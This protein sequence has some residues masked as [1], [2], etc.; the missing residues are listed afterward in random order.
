M[1]ALLET[2]EVR[3]RV[4][5]L[6]PRYDGDPAGPA[7]G[8][9][10]RM[11]AGRPTA[12]QRPVTGTSTVDLLDPGRYVGVAHLVLTGLAWRRGG[13]DSE[14]FVAAVAEAGASALGVGEGL[15]GE[16]PADVVRA[17]RRHE[18]PLFAVPA[19]L[20][21]HEISARVA[22]AVAPG[23]GPGSGAGSAGDGAVLRVLRGL[24][25]GRP[26]SEQV[27]DVAAHLGRP[28]R[29][30]S[31]TGRLVAGPA[32][33]SEDEADD[34]VRSGARATARGAAGPG[35]VRLAGGAVQ[36]RA[37]AAE[38]PAE[39]WWVLTDAGA[40]AGAGALLDALAGAV[41]VHRRTAAPPPA[42]AGRVVVVLAEGAWSAQAL[43]DALGDV[44][45]R[46]QLTSGG[47]T[48]V[49]QARPDLV[50]LLRRRLSRLEPSLGA[51]RLLVG[52][53]RGEEEGE[54]AVAGARRAL[55]AAHD[56]AA[57][58]VVVLEDTRTGTVV[59]LLRA[60]PVPERTAFV[61]SVLDPVLGD[62]ELLTTLRVHLGHGCSPTRTAQAL[63]V[64]QNTVR[65]RVARLEELLGRNL[66]EVADL[67]DVHVALR[68]HDDLAG[69][70]GRGTGGSGGPGRGAAGP[71][72]HG[73]APQ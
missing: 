1:R 56:T 40:P 72:R 54:D 44:P 55:S 10:L 5:E 17:A 35:L 20:P 42:P 60:V 19:D 53:S 49:A 29:V 67:T 63:H 6:L 48:A 46:V 37:V 31:A 41:A 66:R 7:A 58:R 68:L 16:V 27:E 25:E 15:L 36:V 70:G 33:L 62:G 47:A 73:G 65:Y 39:R 26:L 59:D 30:L 64:H 71:V 28:V 9:G 11:L 3:V 23:A 32:T 8:A 69:P 18:L 2:T 12:L 13:D 24:A 38:D 61:R 4:H 43:A 45:H 22:A 14:R 52:V 50:A 51:R 34:V 21:F 57:D